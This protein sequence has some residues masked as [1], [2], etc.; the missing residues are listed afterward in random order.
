MTREIIPNWLLVDGASGRT[1][2]R[3]ALGCLGALLD[4]AV[5]IG[6]AQRDPETGRTRLMPNSFI[7]LERGCHGGA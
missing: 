7:I 1:V 4:E 2:A 6:R 3:A 5:E